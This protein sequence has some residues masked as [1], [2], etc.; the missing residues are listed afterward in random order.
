[1]VRGLS[2]AA[3]PQLG[4]GHLLVLH[5]ARKLGREAEEVPG[6]GKH[7]DDAGRPSLG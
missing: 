5:R 6:T 4:I 2:A 7:R 3:F 1:V